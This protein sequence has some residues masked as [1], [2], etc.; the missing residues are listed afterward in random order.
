VT[1][2]SANPV[3]T[4]SQS[5]HKLDAAIELAAYCEFALVHGHWDATDD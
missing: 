2:G 4:V 5:V 1:D 3:D